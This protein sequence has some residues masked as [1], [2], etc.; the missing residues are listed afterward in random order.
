MNILQ[1]QLVDDDFIIFYWYIWNKYKGIAQVE[2]M[3]VKGIKWDMWH[4]IELQLF[5]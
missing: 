5:D 1:A 2:V 3:E 4:K